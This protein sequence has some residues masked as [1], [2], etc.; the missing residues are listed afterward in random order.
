MQPSI[1]QEE[2]MKRTVPFLAA[3]GLTACVLASGAA[4]AATRYG[5]VCVHNRTNQTINFQVKWADVGRWDS[6]A[7]SPGGNRW[8]SHRYDEAGENRSPRL[9][10]RFDSDLRYS[11][12]NLEYKLNRRA[13]QG[14]SCREGAPYAFEY[15]S[16]NRRFI[17]LKSL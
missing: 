2:I 17:D 5:V 10:V 13:A 3:L 6:Y 4:E 14:Q 7:L 16:Q 8:F 1:D 12:Y 11:R 9:L 15:E